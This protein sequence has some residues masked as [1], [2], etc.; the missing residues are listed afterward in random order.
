MEESSIKEYKSLRKV[1]DDQNKI[2]TEGLRDLAVTCVSFANSQ[3]G[4]IVIGVEDKTKM[5]PAAQT[6]YDKD[7]N[8]IIA[9]LRTLCYNVG[10]VF[11]GKEKNDNGG[12][13]FSI[14]VQQSTKTIATTYDGKVYVRIGDQCQPVRSE[15]LLSLASQKDAFQ[16]EL[17][18]RKISVD[19]I[20]QKNIEWFASE[21]RKSDR[22]KSFV[23]ELTD[24][25]ILEHYNL[26][27]NESLTNIGI[28]WV[29]NPLQRS[30]LLYPLTV[31]YIVYDE[32][33]R[34][35]RKEEWNNYTM[36]PK[37]MLLDIETKAIEL[38]YSD[39]LPQGLFRNSIRH[40][41]ERL[42]RELIINAIAHKVYTISGDIFI[43]VFTDR[44]EITNPGGLP[45]GI[46]KDNILHTTHRR[47]PHLIRILHDLKLMEGEGTGYN[48]IYEI[49]S[50]DAKPFPI[51]VSN[52]NFTSVTQYSKILNPEV[53]FLMDY[54]AKHYSLMQREFI[55]LGIIARHKKIRT[56]QI[57]KELQLTDEE[58]LRSYIGRLVEQKIIISR[59]IKKG[60][61]YLINPQLISSSR[62]D[63][64]PTL[65]TIEI[66]RL[67]AL[68]E[69]ILRISPN[70][71]I[72]DIQK[73]LVD[74]CIEDLRKAI[75]SMVRAG[76]LEHTRDKTYRKYWLAKK[77]RT[78]YNRKNRES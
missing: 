23:K 7:I 9:R 20:P 46:T 1:I 43:K 4:E 12:E 13:Y 49:T 41:D 19:K 56:T 18:P 48:L 74:V 64:K 38:T 77:N 67:K 39:E 26:I 25:E 71:T 16:W 30:Q 28:L 57:I 40:Y 32:N 66:P 51:P 53:V 59:G 68:I 11:K 3:G 61:E 35:V 42:I 6:L 52:Y 33:E 72:N 14:V 60:T 31:Q 10:I 8:E 21:I 76:I 65:K 54:I 78:D 63:I 24:I 50:R 44:V 62:V 34:K 69:E 73:K 22:V 55:V 45:Y 36:N 2:K 5:P 47:N 37:D 75:Y 70:V 58:R 27:Q 29:G 17:Q 15:E